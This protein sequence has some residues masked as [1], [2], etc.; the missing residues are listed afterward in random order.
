MSESGTISWP[1]GR[2][3]WE[4]DWTLA[5]YPSVEGIAISHVR[6]AG[7]QL[8]YKASLPCLRV[9]YN[10]NSCGPYKD[11]LNYSDARVRLQYG[12]GK[13]VAYQVTTFGLQG[14][15]LEAYYEIGAYRLIQR[16]TFWAD[17]RLSPSMHSAG[18]QCP[19]DHRHHVYWRFD[20]DI[21][22]AAHDV[23]F[24]YNTTT[25]NLGWG[26]GWHQKTYE[27]SRTKSPATR[28]C[29]AVMDQH[30]TRGYFL[31]PGASDGTADGFS[32][33]DLWVMRYRGSE[34]LHGAQG[35]ASDD[36]LATYLNGESVV[37]ADLV[38]WYCAHLGHDAD[39]GPADEYH[40][41][42]PTLM[43]FRWS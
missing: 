18:L 25:P 42:G 16:W 38:L 7:H 9:Q 13:V 23:A 8:L 31:L 6:Y 14:L 27:I 41:A 12:P 3:L 4:F 34:D 40:S 1:P 30:T 35:S 21:D 39:S 33:R 32:T 43:P 29:W 5:D 11:P 19:V 2:P 22:D 26:P 10:N 28:R 20:F 15:T 37:D 24:E 36:G 17:G